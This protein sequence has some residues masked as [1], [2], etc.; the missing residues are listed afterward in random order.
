MLA[1]AE[2]AVEGENKDQEQQRLR[3]KT[4]TVGKASWPDTKP[5]EGFQDLAEPPGKDVRCVVSVAKSCDENARSP[6]ICVTFGA[7]QPSVS[8]LGAARK[9]RPRAQNG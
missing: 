5:L 6:R 4:A 7:S 9:G 2:S 3:L 8:I 1:D